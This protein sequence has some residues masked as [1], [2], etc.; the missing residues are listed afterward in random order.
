MDSI[1][2]R[3]MTG[4]DLEDNARAIGF[5]EHMGFSLTGRTFTDG[6]LREAEML[7]MR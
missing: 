3:P 6:V 2:I 5:Y 7:L 1:E 4:G